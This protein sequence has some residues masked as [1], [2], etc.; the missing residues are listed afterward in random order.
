MRVNVYGIIRAV[1]IA[2]YAFPV[3]STFFLVDQDGAVWS[4]KNSV[5]I[6]AGFNSG[7][8]EW[9]LCGTGKCRAGVRIPPCM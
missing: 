5:F 2:L 3:F 4:F 8:T 9:F 7:L 6:L 1:L